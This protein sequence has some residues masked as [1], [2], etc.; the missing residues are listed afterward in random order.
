MLPEYSI[1]GSLT[2]LPGWWILQR[3]DAPSGE[4]PTGIPSERQIVDL[5]R[6]SSRFRKSDLNFVFIPYIKEHDR[7]KNIFK[8]LR[9]KRNLG[10]ACSSRLSIRRTGNCADWILGFIFSFLENTATIIDRIALRGAS[11]IVGLFYKQWLMLL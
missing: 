10:C 5:R 1:I 2:A 8:P 3:V 11:I 4:L 6:Q 9:D 7:S